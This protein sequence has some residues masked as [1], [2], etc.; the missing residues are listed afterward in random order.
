MVVLSDISNTVQVMYITLR[1]SF[2]VVGSFIGNPVACVNPAAS[3]VLLDGVLNV[4]SCSVS[5][6]LLLCILFSCLCVVK[7]VDS[8]EVWKIW[9]LRPD[10]GRRLK[11]P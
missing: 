4:Y 2:L 5:F 3:Y 6:P 11:S 10:R 9:Q 1:F 7:S 8:R